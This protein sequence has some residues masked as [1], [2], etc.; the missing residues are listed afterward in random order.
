[1]R[2]QKVEGKDKEKH[3]ISGGK[4]VGLKFQTRVQRPNHVSLL[5]TLVPAPILDSREAVM[6]ARPTH[7]RLLLVNMQIPLKGESLNWTP[8]K[9][10]SVQKQP[11]GQCFPSI[12][13]KA[14]ETVVHGV[15]APS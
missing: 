1:M 13:T 10:I 15:Q 3:D 14:N 4:C 9:E 7:Q 11:F 12:S 6:R 2:E 8:L 5:K